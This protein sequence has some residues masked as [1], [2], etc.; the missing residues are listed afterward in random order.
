EPQIYASLME[1]LPQV[2]NPSVSLRRISKSIGYDG[3]RF[4]ISSDGKNI[5][6]SGFL[7]GMSDD[8]RSRLESALSQRSAAY[9]ESY[10]YEKNGKKNKGHIYDL[11]LEEKTLQLLSDKSNGIMNI[12]VSIGMGNLG[13]YITSDGTITER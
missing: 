10:V 6:R 3:F 9:E 11:L 7:K 12:G 1:N 5:S 13:G 4:V 2:S 8:D